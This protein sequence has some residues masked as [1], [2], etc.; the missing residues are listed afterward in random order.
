MPTSVQWDVMV[1]D[2]NSTDQTREVVEGFCQRFPARFCYACEAKQGKSHALNAG[3]RRA[4]GDVLAFMDDDVE[5]DPHWLSNLTAPLMSGEW[6]G[7]GGRILPEQGFVPL[8]WMD[9]SSRYGLA[10]LA[11]FDL[12]GEP[13]ELKEPPFGTNMAFRKG[14]FSKHGEFR[15]D[16]GPQPGSEIRSE[17]TEFG[18]RLLAA[19]ECLW[20]EPSAVV[21]HQVP[22]NRAKRKYFQTW[23][24]GKGRADV[25]EIGTSTEARWYIVGIPLYLFR[26]LAIWT[27]RFTISTREP[28]RFSSKLKV[29][30]L[31]GSIRECYKQTHST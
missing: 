23:W 2:N 11:M 26:R 20:Y 7:S 8:G 17:D 28:E 3:I 22:Q 31:A 21:Y 30:W 1:I 16:L 12:G 6:A 19:G 5:V 13:G 25:R 10:P 15:I 14:M 9:V 18:S 4:G 27:L 29:Y 24:F